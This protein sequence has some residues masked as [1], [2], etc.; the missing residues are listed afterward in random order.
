MMECT[1]PDASRTCDLT[2]TARHITQSHA[3]CGCQWAGSATAAAHDAI[4]N[5]RGHYPCTCTAHHNSHNM[6]IQGSGMESSC[7]CPAPLTPL[8][9]TS[10]S[11]Q[12]KDLPFMCR[13]VCRFAHHLRLMHHPAHTSCAYSCATLQLRHPTAKSPNSQAALRLRTA[14]CGAPSAHPPPLGAPAPVSG[15]GHPS[16]SRPQN[17]CGGG[18]S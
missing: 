6:C 17:T 5:T 3:R 14:H 7:V 15:S 8:F 11:T 1:E 18:R 9:T 16:Q 10:T 13:F 12:H 2:A 4:S